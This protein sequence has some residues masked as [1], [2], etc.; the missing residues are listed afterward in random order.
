MC[1]DNLVSK[2]KIRDKSLRSYD[3][4]TVTALASAVRG[5]STVNMYSVHCG[6][7]WR[8][9]LNYN[10]N[11][12]GRNYMFKL[13]VRPRVRAVLVFMVFRSFILLSSSM[14]PTGFAELASFEHYYHT[15]SFNGSGERILLSLCYH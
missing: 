6:R 8:T 9:R 10:R 15:I 3:E 12:L 13:S 7:L 11:V 1:A 4:T 14:K 5:L 2:L